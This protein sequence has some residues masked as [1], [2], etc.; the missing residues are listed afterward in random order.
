MPALWVAA[1]DKPAPGL[2]KRGGPK[3]A[4]PVPPVAGVS[5]RAAEAQN[6]LIIPVKLAPLLR[7]L[8]P[9]RRRRRTAVSIAFSAH[10][11]RINCIVSRSHERQSSNILK[12][13]L[14]GVYL[15]EI[16]HDLHV[17][18]EYPTTQ[19]SGLE[20]IIG[21]IM[22]G[23]PRSE[24]IGEHSALNPPIMTVQDRTDPVNERLDLIHLFVVRVPHVTTFYPIAVHATHSAALCPANGLR[25]R[26]PRR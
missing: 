2:E 6:A 18:V 20:P 7:R 16:A 8:E 25:R 15:G 1:V 10:A 22:S 14:H 13:D 12:F 21:H 3:K 24:Q 26:P 4:I 17:L 23:E 11:L 9:F 5:R 19:E